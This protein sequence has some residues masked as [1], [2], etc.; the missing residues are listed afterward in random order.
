[1][2]GE[3]GLSRRVLLYYV[4]TGGLGAVREILQMGQTEEQ[5]QAAKVVLELVSCEINRVIVKVTTQRALPLQSA[6]FIIIYVK[7]RWRPTLFLF[8]A[9]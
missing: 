5:T 9:F 3:E 4:H 2:F 1:M 8:P 7:G 6:V